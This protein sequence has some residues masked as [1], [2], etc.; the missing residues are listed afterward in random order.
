MICFFIRN[1]LSESTMTVIRLLYGVEF[2]CGKFLRSGVPPFVSPPAYGN[3]GPSGYRNRPG[4]SD[5]KEGG[6][7]LGES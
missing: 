5:G 1:I 2:S 4:D 7:Q 6:A 3:P